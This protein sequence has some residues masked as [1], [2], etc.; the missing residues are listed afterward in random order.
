MSTT[1]IEKK[2]EAP[3]A[4]RGLPEYP[5]DKPVDPKKLNLRDEVIHINRVSKVVKGGRRFS[6]AA[7]VVVGDGAGHVGLGYGKANEVPDAIQKAN[8]KAKKNIVRIPLMNRT[9]PHEIIGVHD[10]ARVLLKPASEGTG[11]IA[12]AAVRKVLDLAGVHDILAKSLGSD[13]ISNVIKATMSGLQNLR[14]ADQVARLRGKH[15]HQLIGRKGAAAF[16]QSKYATLAIEFPEIA[17]RREVVKAEK[18]AAE[19]AA[20]AAPDLQEELSDDAPVETTPVLEDNAPATDVAPAPDTAAAP[21]PVA[22]SAGAPDLTD[23]PEAAPPETPAAG[24]EKTEG[25]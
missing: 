10:S 21:A 1:D 15:V 4:E 13:N 20:A 24:E 11:L 25:S 3:A 8:D 9:I 23:E 2:E 6:F 5:E 22:E 7:M 19:K 16:E 14:R 12:G 17:K 18:E